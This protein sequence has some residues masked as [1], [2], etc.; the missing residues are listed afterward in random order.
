MTAFRRAL[1]G[2][3]RHLRHDRWD[4]AGLFLVPGVLLLL[5]AAMLWQGSMRNL[6]L[7]VVDGDGS[8]ASRAM[9][10]ALDASPMLRIA[11]FHQNGRDA[12]RAVRRGDAMA[13]V[14]LPAGLGK[15]LARRREPVIRIFYTASFLSAGAQ[16]SRGAEEALNDAAADVT[17]SQLTGHALSVSRSRRFVV[18]ATALGN[19]STSFEWY[20]GLLIYPAVLHLTTACV[21]AMALGRE[22]RDRSLTAWA[23]ASY[24]I[25]SA[26]VGKM[27][28]Y[29]VVTS[30]WGV[31]WLLYLPLARGW[32]IEGSLM[33]IVVAQTL[34]YAATAAIAAL[35]I[36]ATRE[37]ATALSVS[38]VYAGSALAYSGATLPLNGANAFAHIWSNVLPLPHYIAVQMGQVGG[39]SLTSAVAPMLA[40]LG[41]VGVA[42]GGA[43]LLISTRARRA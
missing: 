13:V 38:A 10:R 20:L 3:I 34:F 24:G 30:L 42:G 6:P 22:V 33:T 43:L 21:C 4:L 9:I 14:H 12:V 15:G 41:Y 27:L 17:T 28:P 25:A 32:R 39:M 5:I 31:A 7:A 11:G 16:I 23:R 35:L 2:E 40:L 8:T 29:V 36:A 18:E 1:A 26:L 37:T 19:A